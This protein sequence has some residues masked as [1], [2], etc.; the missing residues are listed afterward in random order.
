LEWRRERNE[1]EKN[2]PCVGVHT[3]AVW[4]IPNPIHLVQS[5]HTMH[6][7]CIFS[8]VQGKIMKDKSRVDDIDVKKTNV[9]YHDVEAGIFE[10]VHPEGS[11]IYERSKV[12]RAMALIAGDSN[13]RDLCVDV[14]C[15]T[16]FV[17]SFELPIYETVVA[18]DI[19]RRMLQVVRKR[20]AHFSSLDLIVCD[21]EYLPRARSTAIRSIDRAVFLCFYKR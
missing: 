17:T 5:R 8:L 1:Q 2:L 21:A 18:T 10:Q 14:G 7:C 16:G 6:H 19:S 9:I 13:I 15:G 4:N 12:A 11:S 3:I 20:F